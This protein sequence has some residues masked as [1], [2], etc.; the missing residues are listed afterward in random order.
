MFL[1]FLDSNLAGL[2]AKEGRLGRQMRGAFAT[3]CLLRYIKTKDPAGW[4]DF[5]PEETVQYKGFMLLSPWASTS[6]A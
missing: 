1:F 5:L 6:S 4:R 3:R 2:P